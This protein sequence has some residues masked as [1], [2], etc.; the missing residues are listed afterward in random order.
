MFFK[1]LIGGLGIVGG[2]WAAGYTPER[3][4]RIAHHWSSRTSG[5]IA[6]SGNDWGSDT[7]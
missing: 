1:I 3:I 6:T 5:T 7:R 4:E 2:L